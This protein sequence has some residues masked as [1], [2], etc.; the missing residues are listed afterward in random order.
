M[1]SSRQVVECLLDQ[2][3]TG[4]Q[5]VHLMGNHEYALLNNAEDFN[6]NAR[7]AIDWTRDQI[8]AGDGDKDRSYDYW[9]FLG[10]LE[11]M[12]AEAEK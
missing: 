10:G 8:N 6:P 9:D 1:I 7:A 3:L 11:P 5:A 2:P 12:L 4:F